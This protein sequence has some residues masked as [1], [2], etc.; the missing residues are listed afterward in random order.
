M[1]FHNAGSRS[2]SRRNV[3]ISSADTIIAPVAPH[4][5]GASNRSSC[6]QFEPRN[7]RLLAPV[8]R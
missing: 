2:C 7:E 8:P 4:F 3:A 5:G 6:P 1:D